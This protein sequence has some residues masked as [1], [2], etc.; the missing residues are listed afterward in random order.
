M[1]QVVIG[2][3][4]KGGS[5]EPAILLDGLRMVCPSVGGDLVNADVSPHCV[6]SGA[7]RRDP[8]NLPDAVT[9]GRR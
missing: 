9:L 2:K 5:S 4:A 6:T 8:G 7:Q 3:A 1:R